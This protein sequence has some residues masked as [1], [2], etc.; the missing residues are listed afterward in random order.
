MVKYVLC[1]FILINSTFAFSQ[2]VND[3]KYIIIPD[4]FTG[5]E[6]NE[7][8]MNYHLMRFLTEKKYEILKSNSSEWPKEV[9]EN[10][11]LALTA[12]VIKGK[13]FLKNKV[14]VVFTDCQGKEVESL[15]GISSEKNFAIGYP[16][17]LKNAVHMLR[18][19][20]PRKLD[21]QPQTVPVIPASNPQIKIEGNISENSWLE[22]GIEFTN[23]L[24]SVILTEQ[25]DGSFILI[26][27]NNSSIIGQMKP[28]SKEG[29][30]HVTVS[31][32]KGNYHTIGFYDQKTLGIEYMVSPN[33]YSLTEFK[34]TN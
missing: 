4:K 6:E 24:Q 10:T 26:D 7:Y 12:D 16:D 29:I 9:K 34:K 22:S 30:Y 1:F 18:I 23:D 21:Y 3:F 20:Y 14:D 33:R 15:E 28:S 17:A 32:S 27:K 25:K 13:K 2:N 19:S 5:F 8:R 31:D 11:C